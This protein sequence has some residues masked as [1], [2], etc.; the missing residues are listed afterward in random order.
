MTWTVERTGP[1]VVTLR[2]EAKKAASWEQ[3]ILISADRHL[4]NPLSNH[5]LQAKHLKEAV[6]FDAPVIDCGDLFDAMQGKN[7]RRSSKSAIRVE[8]LKAA[9]L[10]S[11]VET[12]TDFFKPYIKQLAVIGKGNHESSVLKHV[13]FDLTAALISQLNF[14]GS[15]VLAGGYRGWVRILLTRG[16]ACQSF[17]LYYTHGSGTNAVVTKGIISTNRRASFIDADV[18]VGGHIHESWSL[19]LCRVSLN[20]QGTEQVNDQLH[21]CI[22]PYKEEFTDQADGFHHEKEGPPKP[23]GAWWLIITYDTEQERFR[24]NSM[25]A[26]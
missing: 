18:I 1:T 21:L 11:L 24:I 5:A 7:D 13:E 10:N 22:P 15:P 14:L 25:R 26:K 16:T 8:N 12:S 6:A 9:Y 20:Q 3:R 4:D 23:L 19:E 2:I 17:K